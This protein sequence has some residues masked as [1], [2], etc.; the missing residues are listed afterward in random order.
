MVKIM[1]EMKGDMGKLTE[2]VDGLKAEQQYQ[3]RE[4]SDMKKD[5]HAGKVALGVAG[6]IVAGSITFLGWVI[7]TYISYKK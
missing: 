5:I 1:M 3:R 2:A 7:T 6:A 4:L